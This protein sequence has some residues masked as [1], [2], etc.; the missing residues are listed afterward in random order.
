MPP[1]PPWPSFRRPG[2]ITIGTKFDQPLFGQK[3]LDGKPVGFD[4]EIGKLIAAKLGIPAD[5]I[6]WVETV[7]A[8][9]EEFIK[10][11]KVDT[12]RRHLHHQRQAQDSKSTSPA[13]TTR[14]DR[15]SW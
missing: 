8:N 2:K 9:R 1:I 12:D 6:E 7:S 14:P 10:Q 4:V 15:P 3:G 5:K 13:R 11:G